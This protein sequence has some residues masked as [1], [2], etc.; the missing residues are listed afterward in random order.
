[1][2][3][4]LADLRQKDRAHHL[5]PF[6]HHPDMERTGG[7]HIITG[8]AGCWLTD[9]DGRRLFDG[10]AGLWCV[11][12]GYGR[13]EIADAVHAQMRKLP[14][15]C[16]F[17]NTTTEPAI[18]L[19][20]KIASLLKP[21]RLSHTIFSNSGSEA[22]E[23]ALKLI[24]AY[25]KI[26][27]QSP[28]RSKILARTFAYH[29]VGLGSTSL[30][31]LPTCLQPFDLPLA[32]FLHVPGP[33]AWGANNGM[34]DDEYGAWCVEETRRT[35]ERE[36]ADTI[37]AMFVEPVQGAGGVIVPPAGYLAAIRTLCR[38][39]G[40]LFVADEVISGFGR[41]G[42]WFASNLWQLD[43]DLVTMAKGITSGY[44]PLGAT[45]VSREIVET[46]NTGGYIAHGFTYSGHPATC[47]AALAN[48]G[49]IER[50]KLV[51]HTRDVAGPYFQQKLRALAGHPAVGEVRGHQLI[52]AIEL[53]PRGGR[54]EL[55]KTPNTLGVKAA[56]IA[57]RHGVIVRGIRD[58]VAMS[59][60]LIVTPGE[61]DQLFDAVGKTL[62]ELWG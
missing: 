36:G 20:D 25:W 9:Q 34:S 5:H 26:K 61:L 30:T 40:I 10:L 27:G 56:S 8:G 6:T 59:P 62:D 39:N 15:Y 19:A 1:M 3:T 12:V 44:L 4:A 21:T 16:S 46:L 43:P 14:Y 58:L 18:E 47:A 11:N 45:A 41:L 32:G 2:T 17:F 13:H 7:T 57:R 33:Y 28:Q 55:A 53:L 37:A 24:R 38:D 51:E 22:N 48:I 60:P 52:G 50:E 54:A 49:I 31:G 29:G 35:I 23:S 42:D